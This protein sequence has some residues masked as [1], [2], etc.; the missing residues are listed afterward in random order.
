[1]ADIKTNIAM[2]GFMG[3]GKTAVGELLAEKLDMKFV[4]MDWIIERQ[5]GKSIPEIFRD[6]GE[7]A[8]REF[9]IAAAKQLAVGIHCVIACGGGIVLNKINID[10]LKERGV[11]IYLTASPEAILRRTSSEAGT[12]PL[13]TVDN[14]AQTISELMKYRKPYYDRAADITV[15]TTR[16]SI[17]GAAEQI[18]RKLKEDASLDFYKQNK[19]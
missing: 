1:M 10:R 7:I 14:P 8:F 16:L 4:E 18:I 12:R 13:L 5:A 3:T 19:G 15:N 11:V 6:E 2:I 9:E 17:N